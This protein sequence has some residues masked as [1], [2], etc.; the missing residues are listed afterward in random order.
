MKILWASNVGW[1]NTGYGVQTGLFAPRIKA[2][3]HDLAISSVYGLDGGPM[4]MDGIRIYPSD[5]QFG[6]R[7]LAAWAS[8]HAG[9][10]DI[11]DCQVIT[12]Q[13]VWTLTNPLLQTLNI[14]SWVPVDSDPCPVGVAQF[15]H[16]T[17]AT[18]IAMS[19]FGQ[20]KLREQGLDA[21][22]VPHGVDTNAYKPL[23]ED[24]RR[25]F[26]EAYGL[27]TNAFL[28]GMVAN[29][30]GNAPPR[31]AF[32]EVIAAFARFR[33]NHPDAF[34]YLHCELHGLKDGVNI[35]RLLELNG[36]PAH[37]VR[38]VSQFFLE[39]GIPAEG[40]A[41]IYNAMDVLLMPSMGEGFGVPLIEAQACG[42]P[43]ITGGWTAMPELCGAGWQVEG[44][45]FY[46]EG[47]RMGI[48]Q[49]SFQYMPFIESIAEKLELAYTEAAGLRGQAREFAVGYD[50][51]AITEKY[52]KPLLAVLEE[53]RAAETV[54]Q[55]APN[56]AARRR[57][58]KAA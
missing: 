49:R 25:E 38:N 29:N 40:M 31:K 36:V 57:A 42:V 11:R 35:E 22:Y 10:D 33:K 26:R 18:P 46:I 30:Q 44:Q 54:P 6:N 2:L 16:R 15:F 41:H 27:P 19:R 53:K 55:A 56:R 39:Y 5:G 45:P 52:W 17:G 7:T 48:S 9:Q 32:P 58:K 21:L 12:L 51:D 37:A 20:D 8:H 24:S 34:L 3:G 4:E 13:D 1:C 28:V 23:G 14:A 43:V 47:G 50:A